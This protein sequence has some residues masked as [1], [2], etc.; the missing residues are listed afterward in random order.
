VLKKMSIAQR[1]TLLV[2]AGA[3]LVFASLQAASYLRA[4]RLLEAE[5]AATA[6]QMALA[7]TNRI[8]AVQVGA[9]KIVRCAVS[10]L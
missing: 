10:R 2:L 5:L 9:E 3:G 4:R 8:D 7:A 1:M 6:M